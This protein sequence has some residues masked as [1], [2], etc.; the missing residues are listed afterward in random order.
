MA[1]RA[2]GRRTW[3][4]VTLLQALAV[5]CVQCLALWP[6]SS[7]ASGATISGGLL[8]GLERRTATEL[9]FVVAVPVMIV[10][11]LYD[12]WRSWRLLDATFA[13]HARGS[14][15]SCRSPSP[16]WRWWGFLRLVERFSLVPFRRFTAS[17]WRRCS[18]SSSRA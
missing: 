11:T 7:R 13:P 18:F 16:G 6:G 17:C 10:A 1:D 3:T 15:L 14:V 2:R 4:R 8:A 12:L 5:G 9:S